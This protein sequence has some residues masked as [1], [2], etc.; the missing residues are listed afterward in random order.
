MN[1]QPLDLTLCCVHPWFP[2]FPLSFAFR[3]LHPCRLSRS[4]RWRRW[5]RGWR[6]SRPTMDHSRLRR[7]FCPLCK[8]EYRQGFSNC[9]DCHATLVA[10]RKQA[11][12]VP[13]VCFWK[14][15]NQEKFESLLTSLQSANI[16]HRFAQGLKFQPH[17]RVSILGVPLFKKRQPDIQNDYRIHIMKSDLKRTRD[18]E[19]MDDLEH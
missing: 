17:L 11:E 4:K 10:T 13:V 16:P 15:S 7:V 6:S 18:A 5:R 3:R 12:R 1:L 2:S 9:S 14:G 8:S 19:G